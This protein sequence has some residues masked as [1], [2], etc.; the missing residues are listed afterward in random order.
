MYK[1]QQLDFTQAFKATLHDMHSLV[2]CLLAPQWHEYLEHIA[3]MIFLAL[4]TAL[5]TDTGSVRLKD[6]DPAHIYKEMEFTYPDETGYC[7]G[8]IDLFFE[9]QGAY[10][11]LDWKSNFLG[12]QAEDYTLEVLQEEINRHHYDLQQKIYRKALEHYL[13]IFNKKEHLSY[14]YYV[15]LRGLPQGIYRCL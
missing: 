14:A 12:D 2:A 9:Y 1:R 15:F 7:I 4:N 6:V 5:H 11:F 3:S 13:H 10:F 8:V